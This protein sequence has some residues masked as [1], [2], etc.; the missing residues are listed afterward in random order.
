[1]HFILLYPYQ[2]FSLSGTSYHTLLDNLLSSENRVLC[3][4]RLLIRGVK[5]SEVVS[6]LLYTYFARV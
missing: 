2:V 6:Y 4:L 1:M 5:Q 3:S